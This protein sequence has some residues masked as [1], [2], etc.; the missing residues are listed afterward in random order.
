MSSLKKLANNQN[1]RICIAA[2]LF[3]LA[4]WAGKF[5]SFT[6]SNFFPIWPASGVALA[7]VILLGV[8]TWPGITIGAIVAN[9]IIFW[10]KLGSN[11]YHVI[12]IAV[13]ISVVNT[14]EV[15]VGHWLFHRLIS[16]DHLFSRT[17]DA[18]RFILI[19]AAISSLSACIGTGLLWSFGYLDVHQIDFIL[20]TWYLSILTGILIFTVFL[21]TL[22]KPFTFDINKK[23]IAESALFLALILAMVLLFDVDRIS[24]IVERAFP[25]LVIPIL[26]WMAFSFNVQI[27]TS[28][29]FVASLTAIL[30]SI[31][32]MGPFV[33]DAANDSLLLLQVFMAIIA[34]T[35]LILSSSVSE[36]KTAQQTIQQFNET[37]EAKIHERTRELN[38]EVESR[39]KAENKIKVSNQIL[40][41]TN[42]ELDSFVYSVS[43]DLRAPIASVKGLLNLIKNEEDLK[44]VNRY[45]EMIEQRIDQQD[46]FIQE[47]LDL[48]RNARLKLSSDEV[49]FT[50][51]LD[52]IFRQLQFYQEAEKID[53]KISI[54]QKQP[55]ICDYKRLK[56]IFNN[57]LSNAIRY[58][59]G[60]NPAI[61]I[62]GKVQKSK[63]E[64]TVKDNGIGIGEEHLEKVFDMFYRAT[65]KNVGSGLGL[66]IVKETVE[67][68]KGDIKLDSA[69]GEGT[70]IT[71]LLPATSNERS[72]KRQKTVPVTH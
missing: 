64:I 18:F 50:D 33:L 61:A 72:K 46:T 38:Q 40:K 34:I 20:L 63:A 5:L 44:N 39:R 19:A 54:D 6:E 7:V 12:I 51:L 14:F 43:H 22:T 66:Y 17:R 48:S 71:L 4:A 2:L 55:F 41:K 15:L 36:R 24:P 70:Q 45:L 23:K 57:I 67:K 1:L 9:T 31:E 65:E 53:K 47:I 52:D 32:G 49:I 59:N 42:V 29:I 30:V 28:G 62:T 26:L 8:P 25:F 10:E 60:R 68:L 11:T 56:V 27:A 37:L 21:L 69:L 13:I 35:T 58:T 3:L 16:I